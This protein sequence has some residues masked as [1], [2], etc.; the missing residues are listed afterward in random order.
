MCPPAWLYSMFSRMWRELVDR[1]DLN[2]YKRTAERVNL[3][4]V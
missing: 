2:V 3:M 1:N 4:W